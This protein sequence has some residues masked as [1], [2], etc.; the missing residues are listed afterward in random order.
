MNTCKDCK[1]WERNTRGY[2]REFGSCSEINVGGNDG[3][4]PYSYTGDAHFHTGE[5]FGC[6]HFERDK[7]LKKGDKLKRIGDGKIFT[8][9]GE[10]DS[11]EYVHVEE[12]LVPVKLSDF[13]KQ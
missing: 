4:E 2:E 12:M 6:I 11:V 9:S 7:S 10:S 13:K 8:Y 3:I 1:Y 5:N